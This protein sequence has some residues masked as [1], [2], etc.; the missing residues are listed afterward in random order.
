M[1]ITAAAA[2]MIAE[3]A[4]YMHGSNG[5]VFRVR[6]PAR[7]PGWARRNMRSKYRPHIGV[8]QAAKDE[9]RV[10]EQPVIWHDSGFGVHSDG[11]TIIC[12][13]NSRERG[14]YLA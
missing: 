2:A 3:S 9:S 13:A 11:R 8:K 4:K 10:Y 14:I 5:S 1:N 6:F 12:T 7:M